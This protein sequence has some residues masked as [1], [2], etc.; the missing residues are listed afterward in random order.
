M[1]VQ[2]KMVAKH[3]NWLKEKISGKVYDNGSIASDDFLLS[4]HDHKLI[5]MPRDSS[6]MS[7]ISSNHTSGKT[8][9]HNGAHQLKSISNDSTVLN[10]SHPQ[11][12]EEQLNDLLHLANANQS[13]NPFRDPPGA[14]RPKHLSVPAKVVRI[15]IINKCPSHVNFIITFCIIRRL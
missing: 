6:L 5:N 1:H 7:T 15:L 10:N 12:Y 14:M 2:Q 8:S 4:S 13:H 3:A 11:R 9:H